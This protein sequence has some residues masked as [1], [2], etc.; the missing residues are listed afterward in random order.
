MYRTCTEKNW[1]R[2]RRRMKEK[3]GTKLHD[4]KP[5]GG[6]RCLTQYEIDK[7]QNYYGFAI[8]RNVN[9]LEVMKIAVWVVFFH[10]LLTNEK[11]QHGVY[12]SGGDSWCKFKDSGSSGVAYEHRHSLPAALM[13]AITLVFRDLAGVDPL[14]K[15]FQWK[16][17]NRNEHV[18]SVIWTRI[19]KTLFVR[20]DTPKF[21]E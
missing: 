6:K 3:R 4:R 18:N 13:D 14:K 2:L 16:T 5:L 15:C 21:R 19:C 17:H 1:A 8:G 9:N 11:P 12:P 20:L 7:L 10:D